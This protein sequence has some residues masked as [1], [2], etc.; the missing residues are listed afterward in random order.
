MPIHELPPIRMPSGG[1]AGKAL[2]DAV[3]QGDVIDAFLLKF[4]GTTMAAGNIDKLTVKVGGKEAVSC[5]GTQLDT[6]NKYREAPTD[7]AYLPIWFADH[8]AHARQQW[9]EGALDTL[10][11]TYSNI[12]I[13]AELDGNQSSNALIEARVLV[14][15]QKVGP[16]DQIEELRDMFRAL[17]DTE[18]DME[19]GSQDFKL[20]IGTDVGATVMAAYFFGSNITD[21]EVKR[22]GVNLM[23]KL[24][25]ADIRYVHKHG[26]TPQSN[27]QVFDPVYMDLHSR[28]V[29][30]LR[31]NG[32]PAPFRWML[33][34][35]SAETVT[36]IADL[37]TTVDRL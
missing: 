11:R 18:Q 29:P 10:N 13:I 17:V 21:L 12:Q 2:L 14:G 26:R 34:E 22:D 3:P 16:Q 25:V 32:T 37:L 35:S 7:A 23:D 28:G 33:T 5:T 31:P 30:T 15:Q 6:I 24:P 20:H 8:K 19:S 9:S 36:G 4:S 1:A 27:L